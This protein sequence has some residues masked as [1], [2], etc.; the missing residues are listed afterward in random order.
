MAIFA[1]YDKFLTNVGGEL[2]LQ[3]FTFY[4]IPMFAY[5]Q[6]AHPLNR[7]RVSSDRGR[8]PDRQVA[9][10]LWVRAVKHED[11]QAGKVD[12]HKPSLAA[13]GDGNDR[14]IRPPPPPRRGLFA[15]VSL[16]PAH[17]IHALQVCRESLSAS[18]T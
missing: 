11:R 7:D 9:L 1:Q 2:R 12:L 17:L 15:L 13:Q 3:L 6:V 8:S 16:D 18:W 14:H 10:L 5:F 4:R